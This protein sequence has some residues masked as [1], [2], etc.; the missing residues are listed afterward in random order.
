[1]TARFSDDLTLECKSEV[2][3]DKSVVTHSQMVVNKTFEKEELE[4]KFS[5]GHYSRADKRSHRGSSWH[6]RGVDR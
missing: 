6:W 2:F 5:D 3:C 1:M 4:E